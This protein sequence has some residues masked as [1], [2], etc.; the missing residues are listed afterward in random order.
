MTSP[1]ALV[2]S[3]FVELAK[4]VLS[5]VLAMD[6]VRGIA[7]KGIAVQPLIAAYRMVTTR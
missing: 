1:H 5:L 2:V 6:D 7:R 4:R 3:R